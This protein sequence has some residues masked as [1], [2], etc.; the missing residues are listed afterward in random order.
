M[1]TNFSK[2]LWLDNP[3]LFLSVCNDEYSTLVEK[4]YNNLHLINVTNIY[5]ETLVHYCCYL[6]LI[7]KYY[8][9][10]NFG[11]QIV[12]THKG[13]T[14]LHYASYG[15]KDSFL[16]TELVKSGTSPLVKN[17][18]GLTPI[19]LSSDLTISAYFNLWMQINNISLLSILDNNKNSIAHIA[20]QNGYPEVAQYWL[21]QEPKLA[22]CLNA[23]QQTPY[24]ISHNPYLVC[25]IP[26]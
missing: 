6:G 15:G 8:A 10:F 25:P 9:L 19:H 21:N 16:V 22:D 7:D 23:N 12:K 4:T 5:G 20:F 14:L 18:Y 11:A 1:T 3:I 13:D 17:N 24:D 2:N 26:T